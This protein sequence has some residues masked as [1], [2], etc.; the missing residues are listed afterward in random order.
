VLAHALKI[1]LAVQA[2]LVAGLL[3]TVGPVK[4]IGLL[5]ALH[6]GVFA[7]K[8]VVATA[9][10][11]RHH[12]LSASRSLLAAI[13]EFGAYLLLYFCVMPF[14]ERWMGDDP[15]PTGQDRA[16]FL[17]VHGYLCNRGLWWWMRR[18]LRRHG[19]AV[20]TLTLE[21]PFGDIDS[22]ADQVRV[23]L[24]SLRDSTDL[25][26]LLVG[27]SMGGLAARACLQRGGGD[28]VA[29]LIT[30]GTPHRGTFWAPL[31]LG[32][33]A[34]QMRVDSAWLA[35]LNAQ[36]PPPVALLSVWS[37]ED[38]LVVPPC[39]SHWQGVPETVLAALGHLA[40]AFSPRL[41]ALLVRQAEA[42][43]K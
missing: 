16:L 40:M 4:A 39:R 6:G 12:P 26:I 9:I 38:A 20:S 41:L 33:D 36:P 3:A 23:R 35:R 42:V 18:R 29:A 14:A 17:L 13:G 19:F 2:A 37:T 7:T 28:G 22:F 27:H 25:P 34:A 11:A 5:A 30:L 32:E 1:W 10:K 31:G 43:Q 21:P 15:P 24:D 8:I